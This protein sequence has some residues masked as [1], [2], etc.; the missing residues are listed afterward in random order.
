MS[1]PLTSILYKQEFSPI[2]KPGQNVRIEPLSQFGYF[3]LPKNSVPELLPVQ[4]IN[5]ATPFTTA[6]SAMSDTGQTSPITSKV[7]ALDVATLTLGHYRLFAVD[8]AVRFELYQPATTARLANKAGPISFDSGVTEYHMNKNNWGHLPELF[9]Y[10]DKTPPTVK[11]YNMDLDNTT[12]YA[13]IG[14]F[15]FKYP[16]MAKDMA[17]NAT[18]KEPV[19]PI[20]CTIRVSERV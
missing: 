10:E 1:S 5:L 7:T 4:Y 14:A 3:Q 15:G 11:A 13:R 8:P 16:L 9:V 19:E 2:L 6:L 17:V 18:T 20:A 12:F